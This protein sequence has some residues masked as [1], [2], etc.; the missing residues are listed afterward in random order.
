VISRSFPI[1]RDLLWRPL[2]VLCG[3]ATSSE[4]YVELSPG[5]VRVRFGWLFDELIF[6][7]DISGAEARAWSFLNGWGSQTSFRGTVAL[8]G[9]TTGVIDIRL[10]RSIKMRFG[11]PGWNLSYD[12]INVSLEEPLAFLAA[13]EAVMRNR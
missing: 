2:L 4:S 8:I 10:T 7:G 9:S 5:A 6:L 1:R 3:G 13:L 12:H 11:L